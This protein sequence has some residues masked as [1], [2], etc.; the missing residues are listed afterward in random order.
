MISVVRKES[1]VLVFLHSKPRQNVQKEQACI[2]MSDGPL[3][4]GGMEVTESELQI[5]ALAEEVERLQTALTDERAAREQLRRHFL[6][7][8]SPAAMAVASA[9]QQKS[10]KQNRS[11]QVLSVEGTADEAV[12]IDS[13]QESI[14][15]Q[16]VPQI[17]ES[18]VDRV[19]RAAQQP[20]VQTSVPQP[21]NIKRSRGFSLWGFITGADRVTD[22][23]DS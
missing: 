16:S 8:S 15:Q 1:G 17:R 5:L 13:V 10:A 23:D 3:Y 7:L 6:K 11:T 12:G 21:G 2:D 19:Q 18:V 9:E 4:A 20:P 14:V 22:E